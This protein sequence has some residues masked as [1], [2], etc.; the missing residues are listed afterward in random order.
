MTPDRRES[1]FEAYEH[2]A[3]VVEGTRPDQ[4]DLRTPCPNFDVTAL[5]DHL[6]GAGERAVKVARSDEIGDD[7]FPHVELSEAASE[8]RREARDARRAWAEDDLLDREVTMPWGET[9]TGSFLVDMYLAELSAHAFDLAA[10]TGQSLDTGDFPEAALEAAHRIL[11]PE[12]RN[13][14]G[15]GEPFGSEV[16]APRDATAWERLAAFMGRVPR[17]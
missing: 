1:L 16:E 15:E 6:V 9:Y 12:Y 2:A 14:M 17:P 10:A 13:M 8:L 11:R 7:N 5:I 3:R 4:L